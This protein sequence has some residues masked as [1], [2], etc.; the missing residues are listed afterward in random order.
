MIIKYDYTK[1]FFFPQ[2]LEWIDII[3]IKSLDEKVTVEVEVMY[4]SVISLPM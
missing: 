2:N 4:K 3:L 1:K